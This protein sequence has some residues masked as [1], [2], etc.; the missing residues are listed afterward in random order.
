MF[1]PEAVT[2]RLKFRQR[3]VDVAINVNTIIVIE[4]INI[5]RD[6]VLL[7]TDTVGNTEDSELETPG[8]ECEEQKEVRPHYY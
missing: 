1:E 6:L 7:K 5:Y 3:A 8:T 2:A 4:N